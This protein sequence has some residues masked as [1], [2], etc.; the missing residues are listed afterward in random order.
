MTKP[1]YRHVENARSGQLLNR[2]DSRGTLTQQEM[3]NDNRSCVGFHSIADSNT[4]LLLNGEKKTSSLY[5]SGS[6]EVQTKRMCMYMCIKF[7]Q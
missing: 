4:S 1:S 7:T 6:V 3:S 5:R 2:E